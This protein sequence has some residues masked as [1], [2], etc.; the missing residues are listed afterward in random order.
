[1][2]RAV[3]IFNG[4]VAT[5][6]VE[7]TADLS[8]VDTSGKWFI[9]GFFEGPVLAFRF[10]TWS[11]FD[12]QTA[13]VWQGPTQW[14]TDTDESRYT[15]NV[16]FAQSKIADGDVY[17]VN[18]CRQLSAP[19]PEAGH[20]DPLA[21]FALLNQHNPAPYS[22]L[23]YVVDERLEQWG[24]SEIVVVSASPELFL[25]R[26]DSTIISSP[27]K[28]TAATSDGFLD[29]D[30]SE[31]IMIVDLVRNDLSQVCD[32]ATVTVPHLI[33]KQSHPG[34]H[35]LVST[36]QGTL[37]SDVTWNE[38]FDATFPPGSVTGAPKS[39]ALNLISQIESPRSIYCGALGVIDSDHQTAELAVAIRTF[40][41]DGEFLKFGT[42]AGITWGSE[43]RQEWFETQLKANNLI[44]VASS[45]WPE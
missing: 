32:V 24:K 9:A 18:V 41:K 11:T 30:I 29:K 2:N 28:G 16:E 43:P 15:A 5:D 1:M 34:L 45:R 37:R 20:D 31:N 4:E 13:G 25:T 21:L 8:K 38:I 6:L 3:A 35:H 23:L 12:D 22:S 17:Q 19:W 27:I 33:E 10:G 14:S 40:W 7:I 26:K 36:V 39:S 44:R 42:G